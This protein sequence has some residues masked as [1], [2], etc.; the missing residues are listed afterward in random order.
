MYSHCACKTLESA[1]EFFFN[2]PHVF[3][4]YTDPLLGRPIRRLDFFLPASSLLRPSL[5]RPSVLALVLPATWSCPCSSFPPQSW[6]PAGSLCRACAKDSIILSK[7]HSVAFTST[8]KMLL[9]S[10]LSPPLQGD[11]ALLHHSF[12]AL[13]V[14][15]AFNLLQVLFGWRFQL[16]L[17]LYSCLLSSAACSRKLFT[18]FLSAKV[19]PQSSHVLPSTVRLLP[20]EPS[21]LPICLCF[22]SFCL[23]RIVVTFLVHVGRV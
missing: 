10:S 11:T 16:P 15:T 9:Y 7:A 17:T 21:P 2:F 12:R 19:F 6:K 3:P 22:F 23:Q 18:L 5:L 14:I 1:Q 13:S 20:R 4:P 8:L